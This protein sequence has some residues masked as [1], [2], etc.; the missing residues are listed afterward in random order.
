[1]VAKK[2]GT[3]GTLTRSQIV[4]VR[5]DPKLKFGAE[6]AARKQRRTISSFIEWAVEETLDRIEITPGDTDSGSISNAMV[7]AWDIE[8]A[9]RITKLA[10]HYPQLLSFEEER[11]W[12]IICECGH[13]WKGGTRPSHRDED[14][15][16]FDR[17]RE[18][19]PLLQQI[20]NGESP[21]EA[22]STLPVDEKPLKDCPF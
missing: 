16:Y 19:W 18:Q 20:I 2:K 13:F 6:L 8:E 17:V 22:L 3:G 10:I 7:R 11:V 15:L 9:Y 1:M 5:L 21:I 14:C 4:T 12:R